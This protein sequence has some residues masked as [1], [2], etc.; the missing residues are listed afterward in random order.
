VV[1]PPEVGNLGRRSSLVSNG[2]WSRFV[3]PIVVLSPSGFTGYRALSSV[4]GG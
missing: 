1:A 4:A 3:R 2:P